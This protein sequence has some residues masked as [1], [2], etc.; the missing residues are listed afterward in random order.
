MSPPFQGR[1]DHQTII[2]LQET[3][4]RFREDQSPIHTIAIEEKYLNR[5]VSKQGIV[6][7][8][9]SGTDLTHV[10]FIDEFVNRRLIS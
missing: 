8:V 1:D 4:A 7:L 6:L 10:E 5:Q 3:S 9:R 2:R